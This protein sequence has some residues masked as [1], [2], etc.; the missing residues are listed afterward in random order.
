MGGADTLRAE[1]ADAAAPVA[2]RYRQGRRRDMTKFRLHE[3]SAVDV[4]AQ[5]GA[6]A[7]LLKRAG[8]LPSPGP[9]DAEEVRKS[10][11]AD[12]RRRLGAVS[13]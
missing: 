1:L 12:L 5:E 11:A 10:A 6:R 13:T 7:V 2:K 9:E 3:L 8:P 4:P